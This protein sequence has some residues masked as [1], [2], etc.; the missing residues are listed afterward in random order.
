MPSAFKS[1]AQWVL[2]GGLILV[3]GTLMLF[4]KAD[5]IITERLRANLT[6]VIAPLADVA[7]RPA[8]SIAQGIE[9]VQNWVDTG[10]ENARLRAERD[11]LLRWQTVA[12]RLESENASLRQLLNVVPDRQ[13]R[14]VTARVIADSGGTFAQSV[15]LNAGSR[16]GVAKGQFVLNGEGLVGRIIGVADRSS[17]ALL[18][19]DLNFR[20]PVVVGT[21]GGRAVLAGDNSDQPKLIHVEPETVITPGDKVTSSG[22]TGTFPPGLSM[23]VVA[24]VGEGGYGVTPLMNR[25]TLDF[26][27]IVDLEAIAPVPTTPTPGRSPNP[28]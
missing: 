1:L 9:H 14:F 24:S 5:A 13:M 15:L 17:R 2:Y 26:V 6:D 16:D 22:V 19:T 4:G 18:I 27:R 25:A 11:Q 20:V 7:S 10:A 28:R 8:E 3:S 23:G 12:Q 21:A